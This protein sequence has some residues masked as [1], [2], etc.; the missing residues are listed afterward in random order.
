M[1]IRFNTKRAGDIA[2]WGVG[3]V[4]SALLHDLYASRFNDY[5]VHV[6]NNCNYGGDRASAINAISSSDMSGYYKSEAIKAVKCDGT[7][8]YYNS[9]ISIALSNNMASYYKSEAI[10]NL[11]PK[12]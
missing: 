6:Y 7:P 9:I 12:E 8:D 2:R 10:K 11:Y 1:K 4:V 5:Q 3:I